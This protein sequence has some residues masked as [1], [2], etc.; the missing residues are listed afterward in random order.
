MRLRYLFYL[1]GF[2]FLLT[3]CGGSSDEP[4]D[5]EPT[6]DYNYEIRYV[7]Q[8]TECMMY[9]TSQFFQDQETSWLICSEESYINTMSYKLSH[10]IT[11]NYE[12]GVDV[13]TFGDRT[14]ICRSDMT[15]LFEIEEY[16]RSGDQ[17]TMVLCDQKGNRYRCEKVSNPMVM[18]I[19]NTTNYE[20]L[21]VRYIRYEAQRDDKVYGAKPLYYTVESLPRN[22]DVAY[23]VLIDPYSANSRFHNIVSVSITAPDGETINQRYDV[24]YGFNRVSIDDWDFYQND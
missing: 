15:K 6:R 16:T 1:L 2:M 5:E 10:G 22:L 4:K 3:A 23:C 21:S 9:G 24:P 8:I 13:Y 18:Y 20:S 14:Y 19:T 12:S 7:W 11:I 17:V